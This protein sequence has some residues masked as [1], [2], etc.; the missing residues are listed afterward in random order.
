M[1]ILLCLLF[2][3]IK[4]HPSAEETSGFKGLHSRSLPDITKA[5]DNKS[6]LTSPTKIAQI[7]SSYKD[8][9]VQLFNLGLDFVK[10]G[11][12]QNAQ[13]WFLKAAGY[14]ESRAMNYLGVYCMCEGYDDIAEIWFSEGIKLGDVIS[15]FNLASLYHQKSGAAQDDGKLEMSKKYIERAI[16]LYNE[17]VASYPAAKNNLAVILYEQGDA[18]QALKLWQEAK[19]EGYASAIFNVAWFAEKQGDLEAAKEGYKQSA[20]NGD[21]DGMFY[22]GRLYEKEG[23]L[24]NAKFWYK[25]AAEKGNEDAISK[26]KEL[27]SGSESLKRRCKRKLS[28]L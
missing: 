6:F 28:L 19:A 15:K 3:I 7:M 1:M 17:I 24:L 12:S 25:K 13:K 18:E 14:N 4:L 21:L 10:K 8:R 16:E 9:G 26:V 11:D 2:C 23:D 20:Y 22:L 27:G 5:L